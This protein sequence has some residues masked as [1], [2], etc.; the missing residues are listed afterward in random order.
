MR[1]KQCHGIEEIALT[2]ME[3]RQ[4]EVPVYQVI[5]EVGFSDV[6]SEIIIEAYQDHDVVTTSEMRLMVSPAFA[7]SYKTKCLAGVFDFRDF[8]KL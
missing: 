1:E 5:K 7:N 2:V 3:M 6:I 8:T 4:N